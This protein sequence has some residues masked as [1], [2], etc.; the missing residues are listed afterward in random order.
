MLFRPVA[1][2]RSDG[3]ER[4]DD[5]LFT[6]WFRRPLEGCSPVDAGRNC[7]SC[8]SAGRLTCGKC[9]ATHRSAGF[10]KPS[11]PPASADAY[12]AVGQ[13]LSLTPAAS[14]QLHRLLSG[15]RLSTADD[16]AARPGIPGTPNARPV[17]VRQFCYCFA[18]HGL[19][20]ATLIY[21][22]HCQYSR[23]HVIRC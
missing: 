6:S 22:C 3:G 23:F 20:P 2:S 21:P 16:A 1:A 17:R 14:L 18:W 9:A 13:T 12:S 19:A 8:S 5:V 10:M 15:T 7:G 4:P 11:T